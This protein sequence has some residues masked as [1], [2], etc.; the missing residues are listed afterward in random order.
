MTENDSS[1]EL[2]EL[3]SMIDTQKFVLSFLIGAGVETGAIEVRSLRL[4]LAL[5][6]QSRP[7][8][9]PGAAFARSLLG[10]LPT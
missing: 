9:D 4:A 7:L 2:A 5:H 3:K 10:G 8:G 6:I 1:A